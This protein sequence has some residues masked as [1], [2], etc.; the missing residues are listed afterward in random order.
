MTKAL[1]ALKPLAQL[2]A[3]P[4]GQFYQADDLGI[5]NAADADVA[6]LLF[7]GCTTLP[8]SGPAGRTT[9]WSGLSLQGR[10]VDSAA[11][12]D[13]Y[14][15][16]WSASAKKWTAA[17]IP[18][19]S[20]LAFGHAVIVGGVAGNLTA[21]GIAVGDRIDSVIQYIGA[22]VAVTDIADLTA[23]FTITAPNTI[24]NTGGT[25]TTGSKLVV[26]WTDLA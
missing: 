7:Q 10:S 2:Y 6:S 26:N 8:I 23:E 18:T 17:P 25:N 19:V 21:P 22:G 1:I 15:L 11:P 12:T 24:N 3:Q 20:P 9:V 16:T 4:S 5:V 13:Q 14:V